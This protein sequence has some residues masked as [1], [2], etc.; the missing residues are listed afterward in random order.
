MLGLNLSHFPNYA[1][2]SDCT[3][4]KIDKEKLPRPKSITHMY[5]TTSSLY[6]MYI[7]NLAKENIIKIITLVTNLT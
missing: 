7:N 3:R 4:V 6:V 2:L 1:E 5:N